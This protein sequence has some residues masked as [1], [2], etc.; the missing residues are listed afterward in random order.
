M[1]SQELDREVKRIVCE[2]TASNPITTEQIHRRLRVPATARE[3]GDSLRR[4]HASEEICEI[5]GKARPVP[6][7]ENQSVTPS[8]NPERVA[9]N[10][11]ETDP[12]DDFKFAVCDPSISPGITE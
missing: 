2:Y 3:L 4:L 1:S 7:S 5:H 9:V 11:Q 10:E 6:P 12:S 8:H